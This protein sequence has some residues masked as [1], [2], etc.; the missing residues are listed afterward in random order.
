MHTSKNY[1]K[2]YR[3][4]RQEEEKLIFHLISKS[5]FCS[6]AQEYNSKNHTVEML[7]HKRIVDLTLAPKKNFAEGTKMKMR[8]KL[9]LG[10]KNIF[11]RST[12]NGIHHVIQLSMDT[13]LDTLRLGRKRKKVQIAS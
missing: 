7:N 4:K 12:L 3:K 10:C 13:S 11:S 9:F 2:S 5:F 6:S 8:R 1:P